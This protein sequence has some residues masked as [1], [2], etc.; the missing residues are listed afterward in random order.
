MNKTNK[1][2]KSDQVLVEKVLRGDTQ[3]FQMIIANTERLVTQII[4]K[5]VPNAEDRRDIAQDVFLKAFQ[6]LKHFK[7]QSKLSTW[8][9]KIAYNTCL[10]YLEKKKFVLLDDRNESG[11]DELEIRHARNNFLNSET[12]NDI[13]ATEL[14][15]IMK[16]EINNL[17]PIYRTL[18][19]LY[20]SEDLSYAEIA[21][22][23]ELPEGTVKSYLF[24]ARKT[25]KDNVLRTY[26]SS[27][28]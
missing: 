11:R 18:I 23:T 22:I 3:A 14:S 21:R 17:P 26:K 13:F 25:L 1:N 5:L 24:R 4:F 6:N 9:G 10:N 12:E 7:F 20:H 19:M 8:I 27:I 28:S 2:K 16:I 15:E